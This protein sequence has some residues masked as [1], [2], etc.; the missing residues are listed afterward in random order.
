MSFKTFMRD[1]PLL[2]KLHT[3]AA[4]H[5]RDTRIKLDACTHVDQ[6]TPI[7]ETELAHH[8]RARMHLQVITLAGL[9]VIV[10]VLYA[11][12]TPGDL[13]LT[14]YIVG[15]IA[16]ALLLVGA[17][18]QVYWVRV[19]NEMIRIMHGYMDTLEAKEASMTR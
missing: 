11:V 15:V 8:D 17:Y 14:G 6:L 12:L 4:K 7:I 18:Y 3:A 19:H 5:H 1:M 10:R 16:A 13:N 2:S 9:A